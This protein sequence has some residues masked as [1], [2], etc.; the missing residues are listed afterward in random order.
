MRKYLLINLEIQ[1]G[2]RNHV[3]RVLYTTTAKNCN[4]AVERYVSTYWGEGKIDK[5][6]GWWNYGECEGRLI[7]FFEITK[8]TYNYLEFLFNKQNI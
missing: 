5:L 2:E 7:N 8:E 6:S 4:F 1:D 3:H